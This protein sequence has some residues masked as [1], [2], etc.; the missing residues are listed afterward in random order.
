MRRGYEVTSI[1]LVRCEKG[2][3]IAETST[4]GN[5]DEHSAG[6]SEHPGCFG[7]MCYSPTGA[8]LPPHSLSMRS[9]DI[10]TQYYASD[11]L[12][13]HPTVFSYFH[14]DYDGD[15]SHVYPITFPESLEE[16]KNWNVPMHEKFE[17][18]RRKIQGHGFFNGYGDDS[19]GNISFVRATTLSF[20]EITDGGHVLAIGPETRNKPEH[21]KMFGDS[22]RNP[23]GSSTLA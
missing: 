2:E 16:A 8:L 10:K 13:V 23:T 14:G 1:E 6:C 15:E 5:I 11:T 17:S 4:V 21:L 9:G 19:P 20:R 22:L 12:G 7:H 3:K 18:A